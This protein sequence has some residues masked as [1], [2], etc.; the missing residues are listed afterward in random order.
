MRGL[1]MREG[2]L[3]IGRNLR[4]THQFLK[5]GI[6]EILSHQDA[7]QLA[8][9]LG[10]KPAEL[11]HAGLL[12]GQIVD[13]KANWVLPDDMT[14]HEGGANPETIRILRVH[15]VHVT[16]PLRQRPSGGRYCPVNFRH[17][18][19]VRDLGGQRTG[20][21]AHRTYARRQHSSQAVA[22][23]RQPGLRPNTPVLPRMPISSA[24]CCGPSGR[25]KGTGA[26]VRTL[27]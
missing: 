9:L 2:S 1:N 7:Q 25:C 23:V 24:R 13:V 6:P 22:Q 27:S 17:R 26:M 20:G 16:R 14:R 15:G 4:Y 11:H 8:H 21:Q 12:N 10:C 19:D 18:R 3:A 5:R